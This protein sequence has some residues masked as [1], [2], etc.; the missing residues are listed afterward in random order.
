MIAAANGHF[1]VVKLLLEKGADASL[2][3]EKGKSAADVA[4]TEEI[5]LL[6]N[7]RIKSRL[8]IR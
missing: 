4:A 2:R 8:S 3:N 1:E 6:I 7:Q 5:R